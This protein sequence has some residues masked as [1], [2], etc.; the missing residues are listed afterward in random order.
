MTEAPADDARRGAHHRALVRGFI[1]KKV[2][3]STKDDH[4]VV[5]RLVDL[6]LGDTLHLAVGARD[7]FIARAS[8]SRILAADA[9]LAEYVK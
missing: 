1:G 6:L 7:V 3:V 9:A 2:T 4:Y 5:G 8:V